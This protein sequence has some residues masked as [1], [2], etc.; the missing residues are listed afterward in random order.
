M[1]QNEWRLNAGAARIVDDWLPRAHDASIH[2][3][4]VVGARVIDCG[5]EV[6]GSLSAGMALARTCLAGRGTVSLGMGHLAGRPLGV[7]TVAVDLPYVP[8]LLS[9]YA[10]WK[11]ARGKF[12]AMGSG[13]MR[14]LAG[15][16][17]L[18]E[19]LGYRESER[20]SAVGILECGRPPSEEVVLE[21]VAS[22][23]VE[24]D[25][26]TLL[27]ARTA[28]LAG[29]L[30]VVARSVETC[31]HKLHELGFDVRR[32]LSAIGSAYLPPIPEDDLVAI[33]LTND[34]ILYGGQ[35]VLWV[36][37]DDDSIAAIGPRLPASASADHGAPFR[38]IFERYGGDFYKI[39]PLLFSPAQ[40]VLHNVTTGHGHSFG[41]VQPE[42]LASSFW[43]KAS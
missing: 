11:I 40:V 20:S 38:A 4:E 7:V 6:T 32:V 14:A 30:Q 19:E 37:G 9:Q 13:P 27:V 31:L 5:V 12:F 43:G 29:S 3:A 39:D 25:K 28:S 42:I 33:G 36:E 15:K 16:E 21:L 2:V 8:C 22:C 41:A 18:F 34:S 24:P 1:K 35:V 17:K 26:L 10:G 23:G